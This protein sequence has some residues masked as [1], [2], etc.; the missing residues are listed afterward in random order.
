VHI[1]GKIANGMDSGSISGRKYAQS[2]SHGTTRIER[3]SY[4]KLHYLFIVFS[5]HYLWEFL[6]RLQ[7]V[8]IEA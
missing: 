8:V 5:F 2:L 6:H 4:D 3:K 1:A 7:T